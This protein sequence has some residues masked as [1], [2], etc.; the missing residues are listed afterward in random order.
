MECG[1]DFDIQY[2]HII[3]SEWAAPPRGEYA[4]PLGA[5]H[6][7]QG[8]RLLDRAGQDVRRSERPSR[9]DSTA[10]GPSFILARTLGGDRVSQAHSRA[11]PK[12]SWTGSA[13]GHRHRHRRDGALHRRSTARSSQ[14]WVALCRHCEGQFTHAPPR[15]VRLAALARVHEP[16]PRRPEAP[17]ECRL[18]E[19]WQGRIRSCSQIESCGRVRPI[20]MRHEMEGWCRP[21]SR[22]M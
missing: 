10:P 7:T 5:L 18:R 11:P 8:G 20:A 19:G 15:R 9:T 17:V 3:S 2:D 22:H 21:A 6:Q 16:V 12:N 13:Y 4:T 14:A 1:S